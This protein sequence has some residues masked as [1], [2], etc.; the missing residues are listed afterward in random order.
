[1]SARPGCA[2]ALPWPQ[3][4]L[5]PPTSA[6]G[7]SLG[8]A[9]D[10]R[11]VWE[12]EEPLRRQRPGSHPV[13]AAWRAHRRTRMLTAAHGC[14][15]APRSSTHAQAHAVRPMAADPSSEGGGLCLL[16]HAS[17]EPAPWHRQARDTR[18]SPVYSLCHHTVP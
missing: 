16:S 13:P 3:A 17:G 14:S 7:Q 15:P 18:P 5:R 1:V 8:R 10:A 4:P 2:V 9:G 6:P 12:P 11:W